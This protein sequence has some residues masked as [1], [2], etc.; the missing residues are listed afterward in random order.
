MTTP[1]QSYLNLDLLTSECHQQNHTAEVPV[2]Q[3][4]PFLYKKKQKKNGEHTIF[5]LRLVILLYT[6]LK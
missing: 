1:Q 4:L 5:F 2:I 6:R 3:L